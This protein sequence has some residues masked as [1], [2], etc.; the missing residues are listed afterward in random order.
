MNLQ[1]ETLFPD[2]DILHAKYGSKNL[3]SIYGAGCINNPDFVLLFMNPTGRN[4][5]ASKEWKGL[6]A[7]WLGTKNVWRMLYKMNLISNEDFDKTQKLKSNEWTEE[8]SYNLYNN[9]STKKVYITNL[10]K[11]TQDDARPLSNKIFKDYLEQTLLELYSISPKYI[12]S[13]GNQVSSILLQK[14]I[15]VSTYID[16]YESLFVNEKELKI[17][18]TFYP[19]GQGIRNMDKAIERI[20]LLR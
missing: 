2:I 1:L 3:S 17:Y 5:S 12:I 19:V 11:C 14:P 10:A 20:S 18:P 16:N 9:I 7:P 6:R 15:S 4:I 13:F 8:F